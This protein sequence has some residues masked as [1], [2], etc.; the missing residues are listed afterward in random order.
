MLALHSVAS[1]ETK[2]WSSAALIFT[3]MSGTYVTLNYAVQLATVIP[4]EL[5][6]TLDEVRI[7]DQTPHSLFS[8]G[9]A[10]LAVKGITVLGD[11]IRKPVLAAGAITFPRR[12]IKKVNWRN[13][14]VTLTDPQPGV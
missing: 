4:A 9:A 13:I 7:L 5:Q 1:A 12:V 2:C 6:H 11:D 3:I 8:D 10:L 14:A